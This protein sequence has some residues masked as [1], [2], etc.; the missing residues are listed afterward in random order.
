MCVCVNEREEDILF[1]YA[2][3]HAHICIS[4]TERER[5]RQ[6][7]RQRK[8][9]KCKNDVGCTSSLPSTNFNETPTS[10]QFT[11]KSFKR[12][13]EEKLNEIEVWGSIL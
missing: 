4:E 5:Q 8:D 13:K 3:E 7:Q 10:L 6:K 11:Q 2:C 12:S 1:A 9:K